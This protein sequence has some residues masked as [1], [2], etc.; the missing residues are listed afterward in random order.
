M[1]LTKYKENPFKTELLEEMKVV[2]KRQWVGQSTKLEMKG[3]ENQLVLNPDGEK[4]GETRLF[5]VQKVDSE[6]FT[7]LYTTKLKVLWDMPANAVRVFTYIMDI[8]KPNKDEFYFD[9][10]DALKKTGYKGYK[11]LWQ[12]RAW[13]IKKDFIA[14]SSRPYIYYINP[15]VFFNGDRLVI[16]EAYIKQD[17]KDNPNQLDI[18]DNSKKK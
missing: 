13:L 6:Q 3:V 4:V 16:A 8:L 5:S 9:E 2:Q 17:K 15:T 1:K 18:F 11:S 14:Y 12:G 10:E 7:K